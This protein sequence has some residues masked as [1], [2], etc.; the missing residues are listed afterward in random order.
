MLNLRNI[1]FRDFIAAKDLEKHLNLLRKQKAFFRAGLFA[2]G[3]IYF[4]CD[5]LSKVNYHVEKIILINQD[6]ACKLSYSL[7]VV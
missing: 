1:F 7:A 4:V 6:G 5:L 2:V 3:R